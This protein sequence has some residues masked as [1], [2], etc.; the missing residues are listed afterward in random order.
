ML[1]LCLFF[2]C[3]SVIFIKPT[4]QIFGFLH[5]NLVFTMNASLTVGY[6]FSILYVGVAGSGLYIIMPC[7]LR[8]SFNYFKH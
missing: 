3:K 6:F 4:E 7:S 1:T 2:S 8:S 5:T